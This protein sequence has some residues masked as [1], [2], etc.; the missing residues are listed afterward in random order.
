MASDQAVPWVKFDVLCGPRS[1]PAGAPEALERRR[2]AAGRQR[3]GEGDVRERVALLGQHALQV[4]HRDSRAVQRLQRL[5]RP[6]T[7][8]D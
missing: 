6:R 4:P 8:N 7:K 5:S 1:E 2:L 3:V